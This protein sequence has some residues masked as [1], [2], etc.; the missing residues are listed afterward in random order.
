M[1]EQMGSFFSSLKA[2]PFVTLGLEFGHF[3]KVLYL[4]VN[5]NALSNSTRQGVG[6]SRNREIFVL[7]NTF[8][9]DLDNHF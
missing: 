3:L 4:L 9:D 1:K 6:G 7:F 8:V 5:K 2:P